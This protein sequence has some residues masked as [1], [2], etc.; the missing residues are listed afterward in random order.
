MALLALFDLDEPEPEPAPP[1]LLLL[2]FALLAYGFSTPLALAPLPALAPTAPACLL[3]PPL[4]RYGLTG[5]LEL[6]EPEADT[7][8]DTDVAGPALMEDGPP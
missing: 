8:A 1:M 3:A 7:G 5:P 2:V 4:A 6:F